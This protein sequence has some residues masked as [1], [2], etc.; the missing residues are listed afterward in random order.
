[1]CVTMNNL[2]PMIWGVHYDK[3]QVRLVRGVFNYDVRVTH[4]TRVVN[5]TARVISVVLKFTLEAYS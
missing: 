1:M 3:C 5:R 2:S 4:V